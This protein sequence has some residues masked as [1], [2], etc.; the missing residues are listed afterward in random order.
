[1]AKGGKDKPKA[2]APVPAVKRGLKTG[3]GATTEQAKKRI[4]L[5]KQRDEYA[6]TEGGPDTPRG[7]GGS[8][9]IAADIQRRAKHRRV[10][11]SVKRQATGSFGMG[12]MKVT[13]PFGG[14]LGPASGVSQMQQRATV[15][16][17][18]GR[19]GRPPDRDAERVLGDRED[20]MPQRRESADNMPK[21]I[22]PNQRDD[23][24][25][26]VREV[27][28]GD[29]SPEPVNE[30]RRDRARKKLSSARE[31][32]GLKRYLR[33]EK[34]TGVDGKERPPGYSK[35]GKAELAKGLRNAAGK[36]RSD[37]AVKRGESGL[38]L[39]RASDESAARKLVRKVGKAARV[40]G[41]AGA[42]VGALAASDPLEAAG[43][44]VDKAGEPADW[45]VR[46]GKMSRKEY[47]R[48]VASA[49]AEYNRKRD[50]GLAR[51]GVPVK[52]K[53]PKVKK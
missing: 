19:A 4:E 12:G 44:P 31:V 48:Q 47:N 14:R 21:G 36:R 2:K 35:K 17:K 16:D 32:Q 43:M 18:F 28:D 45:M 46:A 1:M 23:R 20:G 38:G 37:E 33:T 40:L 9:G 3:G 52:T 34:H 24:G 8:K 49:K 27:Y 6:R 53:A 42:V 30:D 11:E 50:E 5:G 41:P 26:E 10:K 22:D 15:R 39:T 51:M 25:R 13:K 29:S 7:E